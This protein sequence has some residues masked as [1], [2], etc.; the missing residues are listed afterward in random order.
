ML[1]VLHDAE[2]DVLFV[3]EGQLVVAK[4][5]ILLILEL[6]H[7]DPLVEVHLIYLCLVPRAI[8]HLPLFYR[9][10]RAKPALYC[11]RVGTELEGLQLWER[12]LFV[13]W[14]F[15]VAQVA[16]GFHGVEL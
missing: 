6:D 8:L 12:H 9:A 3:Q 5:T 13:V 11:V 15:G 4:A 14:G 16:R 10:H 1:L 2:F 7:T